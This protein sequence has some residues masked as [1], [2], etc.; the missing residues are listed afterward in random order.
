MFKVRLYLLAANCLASVFNI[1]MPYVRGCTL[2]AETDGPGSDINLD[3]P[4]FGEFDS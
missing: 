3:M 1:H 4:H 2:S